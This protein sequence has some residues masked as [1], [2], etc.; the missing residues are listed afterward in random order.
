MALVSQSALL[1]FWSSVGGVE[2]QLEIGPSIAW[3]GGLT[4]GAEGAYGR[5]LQRNGWLR[6]TYRP[7]TAEMAFASR[8]SLVLA[9]EYF[10]HME[11]ANIQSYYGWIGAHFPQGLLRV[12]GNVTEDQIVGGL[13]FARSWSQ[14][15]VFGELL[16]NEL[17]LGAEWK[18][19]CRCRPIR[20]DLRYLNK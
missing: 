18:R 9:V 8:V 15:S 13:S 14:F 7:Y 11:E 3:D 20:L 5:L 10:Q 17:V 16:P 2:Q 1:P 12:G 6:P 4:Y 19:P